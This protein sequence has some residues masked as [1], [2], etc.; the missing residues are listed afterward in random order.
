[1]S[2][3]STLPIELW[4]QILRFI[5]E[6]SLSSDTLLRNYPWVNTLRSIRR[7]ASASAHRGVMVQ[8]IG[9]VCR[10]WKMF[11][12]QLSYQEIEIGSYAFS[13]HDLLMEH[14]SDPSIFNETRRLNVRTVWS[15]NTHQ[16]SLLVQSMHRLEWLQ[17][18]THEIEESCVRSRLPSILGALP[19]LLYLDLEPLRYTEALLVDSE[20]IYVISSLAIHLRRLTC[21]IKYVACPDGQVIHAPRFQSLEVLQVVD[22]RCD[23]GHEQATCKWFSRWHLP[24]LKQF[25]IPRTWEYCTG[26]LDRGVGAQLE[27]LDASVRVPRLVRRWQE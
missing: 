7:R 24:S 8:S 23:P 17:L 12:K 25:Y 11:S 20:C 15:D 2:A 10:S 16:L 19:C 3:V 13:F 26:L 5:Y 9:Q 6:A 4:H 27:V 22:I 21:G 18:S 1:M 14:Q